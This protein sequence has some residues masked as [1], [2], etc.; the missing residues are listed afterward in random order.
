MNQ[1]ANSIALRSRYCG[2]IWTRR[3]DRLGLLDSL[4][5]AICTRLG[6]SSFAARAQRRMDDKLKTYLK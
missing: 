5:V 4:M 2:P 3:I 1:N 6:L